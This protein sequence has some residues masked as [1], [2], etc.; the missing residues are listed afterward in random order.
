MK[1]CETLSDIR[2]RKRKMEKGSR[3]PNDKVREREKEM[4][5]TSKWQFSLNILNFLITSVKTL[6]VHDINFNIS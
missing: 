5:K 3:E 1:I 2:K 6:F 4:Y